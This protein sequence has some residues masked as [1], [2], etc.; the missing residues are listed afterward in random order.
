[1]A[2][3]GAATPDEA[4]KAWLALGADEVVLKLGEAGALVARADETAKVPAATPARILDTTAAGDSFNAAYIAARLV[5]G[6]SMQAAAQ[7]GA[8]LAA[9]VIGWPGAIAPPEVGRRAAS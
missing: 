8:E 4:A 9:E 2:L 5:E 1:V 3:C 7:R 6:R